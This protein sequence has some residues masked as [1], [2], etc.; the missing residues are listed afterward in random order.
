MER[1]N[2]RGFEKDTESLLR[3]QTLVFGLKS[4]DKIEEFEKA[5][6]GDLKHSDSV[7]EGVDKI[8]RAALGAEFGKEILGKKFADNMIKTI[9][10]SIMSEKELRKQALL[11]MGHFAKVD[12]L[13]A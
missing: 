11:I 3:E 13:N 4:E 8:V 5:L 10:Q 6:D 9:S 7:D 1:E 12:E 2:L